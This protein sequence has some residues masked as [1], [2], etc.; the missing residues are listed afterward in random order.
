MRLQVFGDICLTGE[1]EQLVLTQPGYDLFSKLPTSG[2]EDA[3]M[4]ANL[5]CALTDRGAPKPFKWAT[6]RASPACV[7][8]LGRLDAAILSNNHISDFGEVG[9][10]DT[11]HHL[12]NAG[13]KTVGYGSNLKDA[14]RPIIIERAGVRL[15]VIALCCPT[16]N[17]ENLATHISPGVCP[18]SLALLGEAIRVAQLC[19][20][21]ILVYLHWGIEQCHYP[22]PEQILLAHHA[23]DAGADAVVGC[24]AHVIQS[25][26]CYRNRW[27]F[28]GLGNLLFG[29]VMAQQIIDG[30]A[31]QIRLEQ[32][33]LNRQSLSA[34]FEISPK[35]PQGRLMLQ[36]I[37][38]LEFGQNCMPQPISEPALNLV[39]INSVNA[40]YVARYQND[41][42]QKQEPVFRTFLR[43][44]ILTYEY[45]SGPINNYLVG[46]FRRR[47]F[48]LKKRIKG[49]F[50]RRT[51]L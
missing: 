41:F 47:L 22:V 29:T 24:H 34:C 26:E 10:Q 20:D 31:E 8:A 1:P 6:L 49:S 7:S 5:E 48:N 28:Y 43:N 27:I 36:G 45:S 50:R 39:E 11:I 2:Q 15:A 37:Q 14:L 12:T 44:G 13:I 21:A 23:I 46:R 30:K 42:V 35:N 33:L 16:T 25:Y 19:S 3:I 40:R 51:S 4:I 38:A 9:A 32:A 17:G 18:L